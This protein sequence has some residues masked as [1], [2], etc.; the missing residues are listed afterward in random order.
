MKNLLPPPKK[1]SKKKI[2][3]GEGEP[4]EKKKKSIGFYIHICIGGI[5]AQW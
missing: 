1:N 2:K 4:K 5:M 3:F